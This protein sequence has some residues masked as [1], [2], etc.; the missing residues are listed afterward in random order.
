MESQS[1]WEKRTGQKEKE[2]VTGIRVD[3]VEVYEQNCNDQSFLG[4]IGDTEKNQ[5]FVEF[6]DL[7]IEGHPSYY[8]NEVL[9]HNCHR[10]TKDAQSALLKLLEEPPPS[11][12]IILCTTDPQKLLNTIVSRCH[13]YQVKALRPTEMGNLIDHVLDQVGYEAK[14]YPSE[15]KKEIIRLSEGLPRNA[16]VLLDQIID[17]TDADTALEALSSVSLE[18]VNAKELFNALLKGESWDTVRKILKTLLEE[19][20]AEKIRHGVLGY[21]RTVLLNSPKGNNRASILLDIFD[22]PTYDSGKPK[23]VNMFYIACQK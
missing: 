17:M 11:V 23:L 15:I 14:E 6:Y 10:Q 18:E 3:S 2:T 8:A 16:L 19:N 13:Q 21:M 20:D 12:Y 5:N 22:E 4:V 9:V 7:E 1:I